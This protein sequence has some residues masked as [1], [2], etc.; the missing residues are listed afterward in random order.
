VVRE[1]VWVVLGLAVVDIALRR[2]RPRP[3]ALA[4]GAYLIIAY[5]PI[6]ALPYAG[7]A[8]LVVAS[9]VV[10]LGALVS[11]SR[12]V[13]LTLHLPFFVPTLLATAAFYAVAWFGWY[14][15]YQAMPAFAVFGVIAS[16]TMQGKHEAILQKLC[17]SWL[18]LLVYGY[19]WGHTALFADASFRGLSGAM[20]VALLTLSAKFADLA[21]VLVRRVAPQPRWKRYASP[22]GGCA[23]GLVISHWVPALSV[24]EFAIW[25]A[26]IG[27][28]IGWASEAFNLI[29]LDVDGARTDQPLKGSMLFGYAFAA[30]LAYHL[31]RYWS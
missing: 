10:A 21:W 7:P 31:L 30:A 1:L 6:L 27:F 16:A 18:G 29:V 3:A 11:M 25:G 2:W 5:V 15:L 24:R 4:S 17:L 23:G 26:L 22:L 20:W 14:G 19:L 28:G 9:G 12:L 8:V 13:G